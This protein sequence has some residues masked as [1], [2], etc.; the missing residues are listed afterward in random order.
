MNETAIEQRVSDEEV[1]FLDDVIRLLAEFTGD[2][3]SAGVLLETLREEY[4]L[5]VSVGEL[6]AATSA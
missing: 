4:G 2:H 3:I 6:A 1:D 5:Y